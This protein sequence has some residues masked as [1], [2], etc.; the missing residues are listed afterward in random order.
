MEIG[1]RKGE[2]RGIEGCV[3]RLESRW[4]QGR[5]SEEEGKEGRMRD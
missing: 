1:T 3:G 4:E 5:K 2:E